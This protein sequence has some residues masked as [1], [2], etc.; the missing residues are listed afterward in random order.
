MG[1]REEGAHTRH[2]EILQ[3]ER[4]RDKEI[5]IDKKWIRYFKV[6]FYVENGNQAEYVTNVKQVIPFF[7]FFFSFPIVKNKF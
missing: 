2:E 4:V 5:V 6:T 3:A 1:G 7:F